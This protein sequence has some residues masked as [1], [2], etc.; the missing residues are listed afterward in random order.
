MTA[1]T[2]RLHAALPPGLA[3][4]PWNFDAIGRFESTPQPY[5]SPVTSRFGTNEELRAFQARMARYVR[6]EEENPV[7]LSPEQGIQAVGFLYD[8]L[9]PEARNAN[10][11]P[12]YE[13]VQRMMALASKLGSQR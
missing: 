11:D 3:S 4:E 6:W 5:T 2:L 10:D 9:P 8:L 7:S 1:A 13:S 12:R